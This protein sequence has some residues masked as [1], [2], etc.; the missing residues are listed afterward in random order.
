MKLAISLLILLA[1][2]GISQ[3]KI[4]EIKIELYNIMNQKTSN[5]TLNNVKYYMLDLS[6]F[7]NRNYQLKIQ[8]A[9]QLLIQRN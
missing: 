6:N 1:F 4:G 2:K 7:N 9:K 8:V 3:E 5:F